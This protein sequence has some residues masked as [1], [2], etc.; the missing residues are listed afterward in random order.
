MRLFNLQNQWRS[1]TN[2]SLLQKMHLDLALLISILLLGACGL[3]ILYSASNQDINAMTQQGIRFILAF[4]CLF[5]LAQIPPS[6]YLRLAPWL[7]AIGV[8]LLLIVLGTGII[9]KG[10][11]RWL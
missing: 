7:Y 5:I 11:Q 1:Q 8:F 6:Q 3:I 10:A 2:R 4:V 9:S